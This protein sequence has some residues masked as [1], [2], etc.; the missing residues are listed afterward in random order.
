MH[1]HGAAAEWSAKS[2]LWGGDS[3]I[4]T[5]SRCPDGD[6]VA[7]KTAATANGARLIQR[8]AAIHEKLKHPLVLEF[9]ERR[10]GTASCN[11]AIVTE[12]AGNGS[13]AIH[14]PFAEGALQ[15]QLRGETRVARIIVGIVLAM[16]YLHSRNVIHRDLRPDNIL[17]DWDWNV[18]LCDFGHSLY[19]G[20]PYFA[21][22]PDAHSSGRWAYV[23]SHYLAPECYDNRYS[24]ES[25]VFSFALILYELVVGK[26]PFLK[27]LKQQAVTKLLI[28]EDARPDIP[29]FVVPE[30]AK[31]M[32]DCWATDPDDRPSFNQI[33]RRLER[34]NFKLTANVNT[35][36]LSEF[37]KKVKE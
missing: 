34:I 15:V 5:L 29:D 3:A 26:P 30:V 12:G 13:L 9:R 8:E 17:L 36:K 7:V 28:M 31:L 37:V 14:L 35:S 4:V 18:R 16:R 27:S 6:F 32:R 25:D 23:D 22:L 11:P 19:A 33:L 10:S 1:F 21:S 20:E 2:E 24:R